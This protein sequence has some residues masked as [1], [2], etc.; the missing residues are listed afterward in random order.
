MK[1][2]YKMMILL[3]MLLSC[4]WCLVAKPVYAANGIEFEEVEFTSNKIR[5]KHQ[6][7]INYSIYWKTQNEIVI[8]NIIYRTNG[9]AGQIPNIDLKLISE[10]EVNNHKIYEYKIDFIIQDWQTGTMTLEMQYMS[11][12]PETFGEKGVKVYTIPGGSWQKE[13]I[14]TVTAIVFGFFTMICV[15]ITAFMII[16]N[17]KKGYIDA[18]EE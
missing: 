1:T 15:S 4:C 6:I 18:E 7:K 11:I 5:E 14:S 9:Q 2:R 13:E 16:D 12:E 17:S 10:T 3:G 8:E